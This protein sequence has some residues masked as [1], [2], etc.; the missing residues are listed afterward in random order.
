MQKNFNWDAINKSSSVLVT[1]VE[2]QPG[3]DPLDERGR[4][5]VGDANVYVTNIGAHDP[6]GGTGGVEFVLHVD[7]DS[8]LIIQVTITV[9]DEIEAFQVV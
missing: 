6:E 4:P 2:W 5:H 3:T 7:W 9:L 1:A 8:P